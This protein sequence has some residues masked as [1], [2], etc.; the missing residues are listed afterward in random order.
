MSDCQSVYRDK[1]SN[2]FLID[3][4]ERQ[5]LEQG[6]QRNVANFWLH[7]L[8]L[9]CREG[10]FSSTYRWSGVTVVRA[11]SSLRVLRQRPLGYIRNVPR[12]SFPSHHH[13]SEASRRRPLK[14]RYPPPRRYFPLLRR[15]PVQ[16][17]LILTDH[18]QKIGT[19]TD[20]RNGEGE[21][22]PR[23][24]CGEQC[25]A[26]LGPR[27]YATALRLALIVSVF[28]YS[29]VVLLNDQV[30]NVRRV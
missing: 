25:S 8:R 12:C 17:V 23:P 5:T 26:C 7:I 30:G 10:A 21:D 13:G 15:N 19:R 16:M 29:M 28:V 27:R 6:R 2:H 1:G 9:Y 14:H 3:Q 20:S 4:R 24:G 11:C 22:T 18:R